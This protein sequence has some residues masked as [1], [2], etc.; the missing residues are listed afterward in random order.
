[1]VEA[2]VHSEVMSLSNVCLSFNRK[3]AVGRN[4]AK[5]LVLND[6][7]FTLMHGE[8][9]GVIGRNGV[10][11]S[12]LLKVIAGIIEPDSGE[13][14]NNGYNAS[15]LSLQVGFVP[16][17]SG[18][19]NAIL[20]GMLLGMSK[21]EMKAA[22]GNIIEFSE[23][24]EYIDE[25]VNTYSMGMKARLGFSIA[26]QADPDIILIDE[27]LGVG[28]APFKRK[29]RKALSDKIQSDKTVVLVSHN[30]KS[31]RELCDR[32]IWL[33]NGKIVMVGETQDVVKEYRKAV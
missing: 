20:S 22:M 9:V 2:I 15:L 27:V 31:I 30:I 1:M 4:A 3:H 33:E 14:V 21:S 23:L 17:L 26:I 29:S 18:H 6:I 16:H 13:V 12:T 19:D 7:S 32:V 24:G 11:K 5:K 25:P 28:D 10:G 8:T